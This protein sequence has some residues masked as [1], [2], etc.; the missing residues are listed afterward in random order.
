MKAI[1][2]IRNTNSSGD[3]IGEFDIQSLD[4]VY[5]KIEDGHL[6]CWQHQGVYI[7]NIKEGLQLEWMANT[8]VAPPE[9][10]L[11]Y[12]VKA[13][14]FNENKECYIWRIGDT[15]RYRWR[16]DGQA[17]DSKNNTEFI[18]STAQLRMLTTDKNH[19]SITVRNYLG[20]DN[21]G[22]VVVT[23]MRFVEFGK[24]GIL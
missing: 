13:R 17:N 24:K 15:L 8:M 12:W 3:A 21:V 16:I 9:S 4:D 23:D 22:K 7:A 19:D 5:K 2:K 1:Y 14:I 10:D 20:K 6:I 11:K 18:Q